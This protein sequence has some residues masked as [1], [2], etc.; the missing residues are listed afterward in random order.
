MSNDDSSMTAAMSYTCQTIMPYTCQTIKAYSM[1]S[2]MLVRRR[3]WLAAPDRGRLFVSASQQTC[4][5]YMSARMSIHMSTQVFHAD[6]HVHAYVY[7]YKYMRMYVCVA[8]HMS[9][10]AATVKLRLRLL[11]FRFEHRC[12]SH[13]CARTHRHARTHTRS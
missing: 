5:R 7:T 9:M 2:R 6:G 1:M 11:V 3:W 12:C 8:R 10:W 4:C 13:S